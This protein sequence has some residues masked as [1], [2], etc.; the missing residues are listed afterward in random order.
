MLLTN[1][2]AREAVQKF[3]ETP[4]LT[5]AKLIHKNN[6]EVYRNLEAARSCIRNVRGANG[7]RSRKHATQT[8]EF[9]KDLFNPFKLPESEALPYPFVNLKGERFL[10]LSDVHMPYHDTRALTLALQ[11]GKQ[12]EAD[13]VLVNGDLLDFYQL[14]RF[15]KD[16]RKRSFADELLAGE[17]FFKV[18]RREFK[19]AQITWK[20][21]NHEERYDVYMRTKAPELLDVKGIEIESLMG[22]GKLNVRVVRDKLRIKLGKLT[23]IH[24]HEYPT[25]VIGPVNA[26][27]G[28]FLRAKTSALC[29]HH[30]QVSDHS[31][32]DL[33]GKLVKTW[34]T[35]CL[36][37]LNPHYARLNKWSHG[38]A[39]VEVDNRGHFQVQNKTVFDG[40]VL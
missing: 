25:P 14:S 23:V 13:H 28:L 1:K 34:S 16:P 8:R 11:K 33:N 12:F 36:C 20:L 27:R 22:I 6:P 4:S 18:L 37:Q 10:V 15:D 2:L 24:G 17:E 32:T 31:E 21:G 29:G 26:A 9:S 39:L 3:P 35:G 7:R 5:L 40:E 30:H 38:F 19:D